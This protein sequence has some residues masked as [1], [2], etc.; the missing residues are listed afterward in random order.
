M[1][2]RQ[3]DRL[4]IFRLAFACLYSSVG[5]FYPY[6][7]LYFK[8][9]GITYSQIGI[10]IATAGVVTLLISQ[11][12]GYI[13]DMVISKRAV[14]AIGTVGCTLFFLGFNF[15]YLFWHFFILML[16]QRIFASPRAH[17]INSLLLHHPGGREHF[18][19]IRSYG[20]LG[21]IIMNFLTGHLAAGLGLRVIF[22]LY[23]AVS[24][25]FLITIRHIP[26]QKYQRDEDVPHGFWHVQKELLKN[27]CIVGLLLVV[28]FHQSAHSSATVFLT[29]V[30]QEKGGNESVIGLFYSFAAVLEVP[31]FFILDRLIR[32]VG[33]V[34]LIL[35]AILAQILR[36]LL[37]LFA[38]SLLDFIIVQSLHCITFGVFYLAA[39]SYINRQAPERLKASAQTLLG[40]V[41]F[42]FS[43]I[44]SQLLGGRIADIAGLKGLYLFAT[45]VVVVAL[46]FWFRLARVHNNRGNG[47]AF[48][49]FPPRTQV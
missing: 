13:A 8:S 40:V 33:E 31:M 26:E 47:P 48:M 23:L 44:V 3:S 27:P 17:V 20:S 49:G 15:G 9:T 41:Y 34:R 35:V 32:A 45:A 22:P 14:L 4:T 39:A 12:W 11:F 36:W 29:F 18:A 38:D 19:L 5:V 24:L 42:G 1:K 10:L 30:I 6:Y 25:L 46:A 21:F 16:F 7:A 43:V 28:F 37:V 2:Q